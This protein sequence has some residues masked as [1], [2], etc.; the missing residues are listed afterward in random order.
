PADEDAGAGDALGAAREDGVL[1]HGHDIV[2][3]DL[4]VRHGDLV[5]SVNTH[6]DVERA[7]LFARSEHVQDGTACHGVESFDPSKKWRSARSD[8]ACGA[9]GHAVCHAA[10]ATA[11]REACA[12][13]LRPR[14][15]C[16]RSAGST[17][18]AWRAAWTS[19]SASLCEGRMAKPV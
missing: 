11:G 18:P 6:V 19:R 13:R 17:I 7:H 1:G 5:A 10:R 8:R 15:I 9:G 14:T 12:P 4:A 3:A 16:T 2:H